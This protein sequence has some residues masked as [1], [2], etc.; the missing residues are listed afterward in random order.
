MS[1]QSRGVENEGLAQSC[2]EPANVTLL[3]IHPLVHPL[4]SFSIL[5]HGPVQEI[6]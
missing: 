2:L 4:D 5:H 1:R 3:N 6:E